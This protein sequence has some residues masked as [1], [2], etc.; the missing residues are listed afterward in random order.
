[1]SPQV[2]FLLQ[3][4]V[5][6]RLRAV[7]PRSVLCVGSED[8]DELVQDSCALAARIMHNAEAQG[9]TVTASSA[10]YYAIQHCK[11]GRRAV[12]HSAVDVHGSATQ[13]NGRSRLESMEEVVAIDEITG[14]E[15]LLHDVLS[16]DQEDPSTKAARKLDW[17]TFM[18]SLSEVDLAVVLLMIEG[19]C[20]A[21]IAR[22]L[23]TTATRIQT[24]KRNLAKLLVDYMGPEILQEVQRRPQ[25]KAD[26]LATKEKMACKY[27]RLH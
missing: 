17:E 14:G 11:S 25:W 22:A 1:M 16:D 2:G 4:Q 23:R 27:D 12:G 15:V 18:S 10:A 8:H 21:A 7:V 5:L 13:L 9:K 19:L 6:P 24:S 20:G 3:D 26:V